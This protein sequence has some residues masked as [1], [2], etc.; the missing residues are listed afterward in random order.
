MIW[1][2]SLFLNIVYPRLSVPRL[3]DYQDFSLHYLDPLLSGTV[4]YIDYQ[5][6]CPKFKT[7]DFFGVRNIKAS[8]ISYMIIFT[9]SVFIY[10]CEYAFRP[11]F[12][13]STLVEI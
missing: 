2:Y 1:I 7:S 3:L 10:E 9:T 12:V 13:P 11:C 5:K 6:F 8:Y 4:E